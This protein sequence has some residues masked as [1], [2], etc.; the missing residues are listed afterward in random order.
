MIFFRNVLHFTFLLENELIFFIE[1]CNFGVP[2]NESFNPLT[3]MGDQDRISPY[4]ISALSI[5]QVMKIKR[6]KV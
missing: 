5:R 1:N 3:P 2:G 6:N 4:N